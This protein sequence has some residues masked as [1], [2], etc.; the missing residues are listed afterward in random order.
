MNNEKEIIS[1]AIDDFKNLV[2]NYIAERDL[3]LVIFKNAV[4]H[5]ENEVRKKYIGE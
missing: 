4:A 1:Q 3:L 5:A 2:I